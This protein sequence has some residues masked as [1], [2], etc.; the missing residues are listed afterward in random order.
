MVWCCP[1]SPSPSF[2]GRRPLAL[3]FPSLLCCCAAGDVAAAVVDRVEEVAARK[4]RKQARCGVA[5]GAPR[6]VDAEVTAQYERLN[7]DL[8]GSVATLAP[9]QFRKI[10]VPGSAPIYSAPIYRELGTNVPRSAG[11][12]GGQLR[13][14]ATAGEEPELVPVG[15]R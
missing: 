11:P 8:A 1:S 2:A 9:W 6:L 14:V 4:P 7:R 5:R 3:F 12:F 13:T 10:P 15:T